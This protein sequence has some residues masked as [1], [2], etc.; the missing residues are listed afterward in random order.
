MVPGKEP[1][2][3]LSDP[4]P[5]LRRRQTW[6]GRQTAFEPE[7]IE[8]LVV[9]G[10]E[11]RRQATKCPDQPE[12]RGDDIDDETEPGLL[13]KV[14]PIHGFILHLNKRVSRREKVS[15]QALAA[16]GRKCE[17]AGPVRGLESSA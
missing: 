4:V 13:R 16:I 12:L 3:Q 17:V 8:L 1:S 7:L 6:V 5:A 9:E 2:L 10:A 14:E 11:F 15:V